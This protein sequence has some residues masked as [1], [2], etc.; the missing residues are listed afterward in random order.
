[1]DKKSSWSQQGPVSHENGSDVSD[2][3]G[4]NSMRGEHDKERKNCYEEIQ[5][6]NRKIKGSLQQVAVKGLRLLKVMS[7]DKRK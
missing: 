4:C 6:R 2:R 7:M 1:M 3:Q 5:R